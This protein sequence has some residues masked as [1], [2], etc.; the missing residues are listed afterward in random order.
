SSPHRYWTWPTRP[1]NSSDNSAG[2]GVP[3][4]PEP[5]WHRG[6]VVS[7]VSGETS[8]LGPLAAAGASVGITFDDPALEESIRRCLETV[9]GTLRESIDTAD[10]VLGEAARHLFEAG[11]KRFRPLLVALTAQFGDSTH[12]DVATAGAV[13]ELTHL[14]TLYHDDVMDEAPVRRGGASADAPP[15]DSLA[16]LTPL[17]PLPPAGDTHTGAPPSEPRTHA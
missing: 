10:P 14:A 3:T 12:P 6:T 11:G 15:R 2:R 5:V 9:E 8:G 7:S 16:I 4:P 17:L 13:V 1:P